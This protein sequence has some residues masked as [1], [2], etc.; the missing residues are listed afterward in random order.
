MLISAFNE[1]AITIIYIGMCNEAMKRMRIW[2]LFGREAGRLVAGIRAG[3]HVHKYCYL[4]VNLD[5]EPN[6]TGTEI[7]FEV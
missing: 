7:V 6:I 5:G 1:R 2:I 4:W 3:H